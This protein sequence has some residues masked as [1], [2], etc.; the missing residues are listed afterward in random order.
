MMRPS[1][2]GLFRAYL[3]TLEKRRCSPNTL[4]HASSTL[5]RFFDHLR[6]EGVHAP[7]EIEE[8]H[9]T[10]FAH[11]LTKSVSRR[12]ALLAPG[13]QAQYLSVVKAFL[14]HLERTRVLLC[15]PAASVQVPAMKRLP[16]PLT[17]GQ[18]RRLVA[19]ANQ[20]T[21]FAQRDRAILELVY[22][23]GLRVSECVRLDLGDVDLGGRSL[24]VRDGK[25]RKDRSVPLVGRAREALR[26]Y[27]TTSRP[28]LLRWS[29]E[30][31]LFLA[32]G[33]GRLAGGSVQMMV[34]DSGKRAGVGASCH[35]LR[36][37]YATHL[38]RGGA[39]IR[40]IQALLGHRH[41]TT[42]A[43]YT[44][45]DTTDLAAM[46]SRSHP[47]ERGKARANTATKPRRSLRR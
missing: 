4:R 24:L 35:V 14:A 7:H 17:E 8:A 37:S 27:L 11:Q 43:L 42:T 5:P 26:A 36:H 32:R 12:G 29:T 33:A 18:V 9:V 38:L 23:T 1:L 10:G 13:T 28:E 19:S 39:D 6:A 22:G 21:I 47:R 20:Q 30:R 31:A 2:D 44:R 3:D 45:V 15:D 34:R 40:Q 16:R 41:L 25:G 46:L